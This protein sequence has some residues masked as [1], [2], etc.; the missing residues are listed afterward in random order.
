MVDSTR[1]FGS[2][3]ILLQ[4]IVPET[5]HLHRHILRFLLSTKSVGRRISEMV[6]AEWIESA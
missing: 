6:E 1:S 2:Q 5:G 4:T 3:K